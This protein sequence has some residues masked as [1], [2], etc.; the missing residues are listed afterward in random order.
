[1][2]KAIISVSLIITILIT[3][4]GVTVSLPANNGSSDN[5]IAVYNDRNILEFTE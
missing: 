2:K 5:Q 4:A 3:I 1:M